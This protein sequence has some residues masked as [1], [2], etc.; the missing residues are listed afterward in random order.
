MG[1]CSTCNRAQELFLLLFIYLWLSEYS[2]EKSRTHSPHQLWINP[3]EALDTLHETA[4]TIPH[5]QD[6]K[7]RNFDVVDGQ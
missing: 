1:E 7:R 6:P 5:P 2:G 3:P 4:T